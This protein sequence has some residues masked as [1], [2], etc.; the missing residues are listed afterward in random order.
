[1]LVLHTQPISNPLHCNTLHTGPYW[2]AKGNWSTAK[3]ECL[4]AKG[5][6]CV[7]DYADKVMSASSAGLID[8]PSNL[9][10]DWVYIFS[11]ANDSVIANGAAI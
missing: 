10:T 9:P 11:A 3:A 5:A 4:T 6:A 1:M 2:C 8:P 7:D